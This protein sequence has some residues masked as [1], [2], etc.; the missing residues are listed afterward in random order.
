MVAAFR[1]PVCFINLGLIPYR[2]RYW[3]YL[4]YCYSWLLVAVN[5]KYARS[6]TFLRE[7]ERER[8]RELY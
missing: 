2:H 1:A 4:Y 3:T 5:R 8:E 6:L 7:R